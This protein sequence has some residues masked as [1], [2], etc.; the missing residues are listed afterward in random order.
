MTET[1]IPSNA[2][3]FEKSDLEEACSCG[4]VMVCHCLS[5]L[6]TGPSQQPSPS[7]LASVAHSC[8]GNAR[9]LSILQPKIHSDLQKLEIFQTFGIVCRQDLQKLIRFPP[10]LTLYLHQVS[11]ALSS[12]KRP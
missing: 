6:P 3:F 2:Q 8:I 5:L 7:P 11:A 4:M 9:Q 10:I 12:L 1:C